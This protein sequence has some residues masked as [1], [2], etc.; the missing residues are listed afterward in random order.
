MTQPREQ[1]A[2][3][4]STP[5]QMPGVLAVVQQAAAAVR[6]LYPDEMTP[7]ARRILLGILDPQDERRGGAA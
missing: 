5:P 7:T 3:E 4:P 6:L 2:P 1:V